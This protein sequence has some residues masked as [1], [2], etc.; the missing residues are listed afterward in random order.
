MAKCDHFIP[1]NMDTFAHTKKQK[2][3]KKKSLGTILGT[4][5]LFCVKEEELWKLKY[6]FHHAKMY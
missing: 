5:V 3:T 2:K 6:L 1:E 4:W